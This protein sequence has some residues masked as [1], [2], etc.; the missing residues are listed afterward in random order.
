MSDSPGKMARYI[1]IGGFLGAGKSTAVAALAQRLAQRGLRVGLITNDQSVGLVDTAFLKSRGFDVEE[2]AGGCFC[3]RFDSLLEASN[4]LEAS[5]APHVFIAEPVG[6][7]TDLVA[8]VS[9]PLRRL[10]GDRFTIAPLSV[11]V[12]P[13]RAARVFG[14]IE[15]PTFSHKV[16][17]VYRKQLEESEVIVI[18]KADAVDAELLARLRARLAEEFLHA[19][20]LAASCRRG[21]GLDAW[22]DLLENSVQGER[23]TMGI[24]YDV[25]AEGE[26]LLGWLNATIRVEGSQLFD[27]EVMMMC[28][29]GLLQQ[30]LT[31]A[32]GEI[33]HLKMTLVSDHQGGSTAVL[34]LVRNDFVPEL[35]Q[36]LPEPILSGR[37]IVNLRAEHA[38]EL[39]R[40]ALEA[41]LTKAAA[42]HGAVVRIEH[43]EQL[44][45]GRPQPTWRMTD[46][47]EL[48]PFA[49]NPPPA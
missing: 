46:A 15:G 4:L 3:C 8:T 36:S 14:L 43:A 30:A 19:R 41:A 20:V 6:S 29:A 24:D 27:G 47:A 12:D 16:V 39:L 18:N 42:E 5:V 2:I 40:A 22:F 11:V 25:Y 44:R 9:Y 38:P 10:Y 7:C 26:A 49:V 34:N 28:L 32:G 1:M 23:R 33:A 37:L 21:D 13:V 48:K 45:P 35:S 31:S 17:Y